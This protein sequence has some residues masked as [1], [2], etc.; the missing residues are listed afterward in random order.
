MQKFSK[1]LLSGTGL[2]ARFR[3]WNYI[4]DPYYFM[5][6]DEIWSIIGIPEGRVEVDFTKSPYACNQVSGDNIGF[7]IEGF[8]KDAVEKLARMFIDF[9]HKSNPND[10]LKVPP[11][12]IDR[13]EMTESEPTKE[14]IDRKLES[15]ETLDSLQSSEVQPND[16]TDKINENK[17]SFIDRINKAFPK[18]STIEVGDLESELKN[19]LYVNA[20]KMI[21]GDYESVAN[22]LYLFNLGFYLGLKHG[23]KE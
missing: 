14:C 7:V 17:G 21:K 5:D 12:I 10:F 18:I 4:G 23:N 22:N 15:K 11:T 2:S 9:L 13:S 16:S 1:G 20:N 6:L 8:D 19:I 3:I